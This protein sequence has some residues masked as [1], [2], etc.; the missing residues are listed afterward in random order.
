[1][2]SVTVVVSIFN[3]SQF[4][5][6]SIKY[7]SEQEFTDFEVL[8]VVD[9]KTTDDTIEK[10]NEFGKAL[11]SH[12]TIMQDDDMALPGSRNLGLSAAEGQ[13]I[14]FMDVDDRPYPDF[15]KIMV[16]LAEEHH[17]DFSICNYIRSESLDTKETRKKGRV[18][19]MDRNQGMKKLMSDRIPVATWSKVIRTEFLRKNDLIFLPGFSE[20][21]DHTHRMMLACS[22]AVYCSKPLYLYHQNAESL[23][24]SLGDDRGQ[25]EIRVYRELM[26][27]FKNTD[28]DDAMC[29]RAAI[30]MLRSAVHMSYKTFLE[31]IKSD[32]FKECGKYLKNPLTWEYLCVKVSPMAYF[33]IVHFYL[34]FFYYRDLRCYTRI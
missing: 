5:E 3:G 20:D 30:M 4:I 9:S 16:R 2:P 12:R 11:P 18:F 33:K 10:I 28:H 6:G 8:F 31:F 26:D 34:Q 25:S 21:V 14:W 29:R 23:V 17:A 24:A 22:K 19:I 13:Y 15:L 1:M 7:L 32:E 27:K